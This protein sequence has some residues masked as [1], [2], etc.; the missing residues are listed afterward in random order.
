M[1][2]RSIV[3]LFSI[4]KKQPFLL[5]VFL[6]IILGATFPFY[7]PPWIVIV[8]TS[9]G[10]YTILSVSWAAFCVPTNYIS[11]ATSTFFGVGIYASAIFQD[12]PL[13]VVI[14]IAGGIS[15][16]VGLLVGLAT[17]RLHGMYFAIFTFGLTELARH[18][19]TWYEVNIT[20]TVGRYLPPMNLN[21]A[22]YYI[23]AL[24]VVTLIFFYFFRRHRFG[25]AL[26][27]IGQSAEA[28]A[29]IGI[30]VNQV[31]ILSFAITCFFMGATGAIMAT[32]WSY[33]D[34]SLA[35]HPFITFFAV[36]MVIVGGW[37]S[38]G[39]GPLIGSIV[40]TTLS[41]TVLAEVANLTMLLF[42]VILIAV[43]LFFPGG[44]MGLVESRLKDRQNKDSYARAP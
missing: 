3:D 11:L 18:L 7:V 35:F 39:W 13:P 42:G 10:M 36:M 1:G 5:A 41:D 28:A 6:I 38:L 14:I 23:L 30:N 44:I 12:L 21:T 22:Y 20:G 31:K 4:L 34:P 16:G 29:H 19:M 15:L 2:K 26:R 27:S 32:R 40:L 43:I 8:F 9:I 37:Y 25:V 24:L 17:L 33:V